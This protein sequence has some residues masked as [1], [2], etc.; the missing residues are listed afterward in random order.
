M[1]DF[2]ITAL[3]WADL[4]RLRAVVRRVHMR[5]YPADFCTDREA[6]MIICSLAPET[7]E[8]MIKIAVE[9]K[10]TEGNDVRPKHRI[11]LNR[12]DRGRP[13]RY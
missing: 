10:L 7:A 9:D 3:S 6:D 2:D 5:H 8:K 12:N 4:Q 11:N 1:A 13:H